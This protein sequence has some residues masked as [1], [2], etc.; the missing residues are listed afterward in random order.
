MAPRAQKPE[1][2]HQADVYERNV[3][4]WSKQMAPDFVRW[5]GVPPGGRWLDVGCGTA[6]L[7]E[8]ILA[9]AS[10]ANVV[11]VD[12]SPPF[13]AYTSA[14]V[15]DPRASF[16]VGDAMALEF[17]EGT[18]DAAAAALVL[19]FVPDPNVATAEMRRVVKSGGRI[20]A[21]E[22]DQE[23]RM[24]HL[25]WDAAVEQDPAA[26][27]Y[28]EGRR[29]IGPDALRACYIGAGL[30]QV[31]LIA[32]DIDLAFKDFDDYSQPFLGGQGPA[33]PYVKSLA[34]DRRED[35]VARLRRR[36]GPGGDGSIRMV[37]RT[38]A[39]RGVVP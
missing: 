27:Q 3:G 26:A 24:S 2:F 32:L 7:T 33:G 10:P 21:T 8:A 37:S 6:A 4:R 9:N 20:G 16:R 13:V 35:L 18:F 30:Q 31:E 19:H 39:V 28:D 23:M 1:L 36:L 34:P 29:L 14:A 17:A 12:P 5:L 25:F 22:W 11:G 38:W 15:R